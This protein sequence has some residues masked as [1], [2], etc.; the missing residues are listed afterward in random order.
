[1]IL[2]LIGCAAVPKLTILDAINFSVSAWNRVTSKTIM[3]SWRRADILPHGIFERS[4]SEMDTVPNETHEAEIEIVDLVRQLPIDDPIS[5]E[6]NI[7]I[8]KA[9]DLNNSADDVTLMQQ[10]VDS[11]E[12]ESVQ[13]ERIVTRESIHLHFLLLPHYLFPLPSMVSHDASPIG[14]CSASELKLDALSIGEF[15][16]VMLSFYDCQRNL[17]YCH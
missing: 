11:Q 5:A 10:I 4:L 8:D 9:I 2:D 12:D 1:M 6:N 15:T 17:F 16:L 3:S 7:N 13:S 14:K